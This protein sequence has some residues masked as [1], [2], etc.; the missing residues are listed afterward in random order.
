M[1]HKIKAV[2]AQSIERAASALRRRWVRHRAIAWRSAIAMMVVVAA[3]WLG[4]QF[5]RL[6]W[7]TGYW[8]A[9]D[10]K[11][12]H[13]VLNALLE[14]RPVYTQ[15]RPAATYPPGSYLLL[16][17]FLGWLEFTPARWLWAGTAIGA[18][19]WLIFLII[20]ESK[21]DTVLERAF[22]SLM[23]LSMYATG[24][25][26][27]NGQLM[28]HLLPCLLASLKLLN[29]EQPGWRNDI[30][31]ALL[32]IFTL[33]KPSVS[34]PFFWLVIFRAAGLRPAALVVI[35][36]FGLTL[37]AT[38]FQPANLLTV[39]GQ[40]LAHPA[41][42]QPGQANLRAW[43]VALGLGEWSSLASVSLLAAL[44]L[45]TYYHRR[46][47]LWLL[48]GVTAIVS[49]FWVSHRWFDDLLILL[50]M[51]TLFR[52][53]KAGPSD[54]S[55]I[56]AAVLLFVSVAAMLAPGGLYLFP[57]PWNT[58]YTTGQTLIWLLILIFLSNRARC[59]RRKNPS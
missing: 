33:I 6:L 40:W 51:V 7:Q 9:I 22:V 10:L 46:V 34:A 35:A 56:L 13:Q 52:I 16:W 19:W 28:V 39:L 27:G 23:P 30:L 54:G 53:A 8:G 55:D 43:L 24:A 45:W 18:L 42:G 48:L 14:G 2:L 26:I 50:P 57:S 21:S 29:R 59:N 4:Y 58:I 17:P 37:F 41:M 1:K 3:L 5:W 49:R 12:K 38:S 36:Y 32:F 20:R 15:F 11:N 31:G 47:D 44:G 25:T